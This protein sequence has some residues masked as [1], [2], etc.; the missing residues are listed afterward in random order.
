MKEKEGGLCLPGEELGN[1]MCEP[2]SKWCLCQAAALWEEFLEIPGGGRASQGKPV[3]G[4]FIV[5]ER[6][7]KE[8][9]QHGLRTVYSLALVLAARSGL[10]LCLSVW[11]PKLFRVRESGLTSP[12]RAA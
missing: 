11:R 4:H 3:Q 6:H 12:S 10:S 2:I 5:C 9:Q 8:R 1:G 7:R